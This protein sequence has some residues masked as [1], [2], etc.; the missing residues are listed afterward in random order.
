[1]SPTTNPESDVYDSI[2]GALGKL[3]DKNLTDQQTAK[4]IDKLTDTI[5]HLQA[6][7]YSGE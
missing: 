5:L 3:K 6:G 1:M 2:V 7:A 4:L